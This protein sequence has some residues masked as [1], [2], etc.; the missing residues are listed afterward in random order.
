MYIRRYKYIANVFE[1]MTN[2]LRVFVMRN[3]LYSLNITYIR[4]II[5]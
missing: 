1:D 2:I 4:V 5:C 3:C